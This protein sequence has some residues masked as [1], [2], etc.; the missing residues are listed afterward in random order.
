MRAIIDALIGQSKTERNESW[1]PA[2]GTFEV[3]Y[4]R[5]GWRVTAALHP[6]DCLGVPSTVHFRGGD[7]CPRIHGRFRR[8]STGRPAG[9]SQSV[10]SCV[11]CLQRI[12]K[13]SGKTL[14]ASSAAVRSG[15]QRV[16]RWA[17][18]FKKCAAAFPVGA[19]RVPFCVEDGLL[20]L[21]H[22]FF[23][24]TQPTPTF[25]LGITRSRQGDV[26]Q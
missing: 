6:A 26:Q 9:P 18:V 21:L 19:A 7:G 2:L 17:T 5:L 20:V 16:D 15:R 13:S 12:A 22:P 8:P 25:D 24:T 4:G 11:G 3:H 23:K 10:T 14:P 1:G